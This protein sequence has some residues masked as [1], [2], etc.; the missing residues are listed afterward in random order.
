MKSKG[1]EYSKIFRKAGL[2]WGK[3]NLQQAIAILQAGLALAT[4][5]GDADVAHVLR[6]DLERYRRLEAGAETDRLC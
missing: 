2:A 6:G 5:H 4:A 1:A 3:G